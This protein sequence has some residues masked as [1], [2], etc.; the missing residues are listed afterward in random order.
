MSPVTEALFLSEKI[1]KTFPLHFF[2]VSLK[3]KREFI[4][5]RTGGL[6]VE[7]RKCVEICMQGAGVPKNKK[8]NNNIKK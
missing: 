6:D 5:S 2:R 4:H 1:E 8:S 7:V 3:G